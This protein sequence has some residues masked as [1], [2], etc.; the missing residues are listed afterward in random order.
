MINPILLDTSA[1]ERLLLNSLCLI[2]S[3]IIQALVFLLRQLYFLVKYGILRLPHPPAGGA[4]LVTAAAA[5]P[6]ELEHPAMPHLMVNGRLTAIV[7]LLQ[8]EKAYRELLELIDEVFRP[9]IAPFLSDDQS[10]LFFAELGTFTEI[11]VRIFVLLKEEE[12]NGAEYA[13]VGKVFADQSEDLAAFSSWIDGHLDRALTFY[14]L[15]YENKKFKQKVKGIERRSN[16]KFLDMIALP[17]SHVMAWSE[18]LAKFLRFTPEWH[19]DFEALG[20]ATEA[21]KALSVR[22]TCIIGEG[23]RRMALLDEERKIRKC[24]PLMD[25]HRRVVGIWPMTEERFFVHL[26][27]DM[28]LIVQQ[29]V[30]ILSRKKYF[31]IQR[32]IKVK[33]VVDVVREKAGVKLKLRGASD[34]VLLISLKGDELADSLR[35]QLVVH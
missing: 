14:R 16:Q 7:E 17:L 12:K 35:A 21:V 3:S 27:T 8:T 9:G 10:A 6:E 34:I 19:I 23:R 15:Y 2:S 32:D 31:V 11:S 13:Q 26:F 24:P 28:I 1:L 25:E 18:A 29:R 30:E 33:D 20:Q 22:A 5:P 4:I